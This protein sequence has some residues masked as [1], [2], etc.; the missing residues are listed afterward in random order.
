MTDQHPSPCYEEVAEQFRALLKVTERVNNEC[1]WTKVQQPEQHLA[2]IQSE[3]EEISVELTKV[4]YVILLD[5]LLCMFSVPKT[6]QDDILF[7]IKVP[8]R[9]HVN[10]WKKNSEIS[11]LRRCF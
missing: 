3:L 7:L 11:C 2:H 4:E 5:F 9:K 10:F 1:V 6:T 8:Y